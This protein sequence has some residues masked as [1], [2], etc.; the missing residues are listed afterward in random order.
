M[1]SHSLHGSS[2]ESIT[3]ND[4]KNTLSVENQND[5]KEFNK[6]DMAKVISIV[7]YLT[8]IGWLVAMMLY[9]N[10][11]SAQTRFHLRQALGL[12]ITAAL[13]SFIPLIGWALN[14]AIIVLWFIALVNAIK[15]N[16][17]KVPVIGNFYQEHLDFIR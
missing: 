8:L 13:L 17:Y 7:C 9:G 10:H 1:Q 2:P 14:L 11:K 15:G 5:E 6:T 16:Q 12:I 4:E 3:K